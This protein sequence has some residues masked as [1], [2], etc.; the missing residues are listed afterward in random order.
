MYGLPKSIPTGFEEVEWAKLVG[1]S[2]LR[3]QVGELPIASGGSDHLDA[4]T[5]SLRTKRSMLLVNLVTPISCFSSQRSSRRP[6]NA[7]H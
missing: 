6:H 1:A 7:K 3:L 5:N 2:K 4:G